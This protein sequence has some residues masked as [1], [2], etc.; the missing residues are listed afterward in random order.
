MRV[1]RKDLCILRITKIGRSWY[2]CITQLLSASIHF[3]YQLTRPLMPSWTSDLFTTDIFA[4][5]ASLI[6]FSILNHRPHLG[7]LILVENRKDWDLKSTADDT[8][9]HR[10]SVADHTRRDM[11]QIWRWSTLLFWS[12]CWTSRWPLL[13]I[14]TPKSEARYS[15]HAWIFIALDISFWGTRRHSI[16]TRSNGVLKLGDAAT[17]HF[18]L[19]LSHCGF[20]QRIKEPCINGD[21]NPRRLTK[22]PKRVYNLYLLWLNP[23]FMVTEVVSRMREVTLNNGDQF[24][25][26]FVTPCYSSKKSKAPKT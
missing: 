2:Y 23:M 7:S 18:T 4:L 20:F 8:Q 24:L 25:Q 10:A 1:S 3:S 15:R 6:S 5:Q 12:S 9:F 14:D 21:S 11:W 13:H 17:S 19:D 16:A 22:P 26:I